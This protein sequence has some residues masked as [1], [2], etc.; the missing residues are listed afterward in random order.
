MTDRIFINYRRADSIGTAGRLRD[1]LAETFGQQNFFM[2]VDS[3]PA[4]VDFVADLNSQVAQCNVF[5]VVI[6]A[7]W[8]DS[9]DE[10]GARRLDKPDDFV[11]IEIAAALARDMRQVSVIPVLVDGARMARAD[12]LPASIQPLS[13]RQAVELRNA[14]FGRDVEIL[15][16]KVRQARGEWAAG[17]RR[18]RVVAGAAAL[19]VAILAGSIAYFWTHQRATWSVANW[20]SLV[21]ISTTD[22][23]ICTGAVIAPTAVL[24][25]ANC[26]HQQEPTH[27]QVMTVANDGNHI[28]LGDPIPVSKID[29]NPEYTHSGRWPQND[30]AILEL[31]MKLPPPFAKI[32]AQRSSDPKAGDLAWVGIIDFQSAPATFL[33]GSVAIWDDATCA[34]K[35]GL[36]GSALEK[37]I[38]AGSEHTRAGV[39]PPSGSAGGPLLISNRADRKLQ[40]GFVSAANCNDPEAAY[41]IYTRISSYAD[42]IKKVAPDAFTEP[43]PE[44]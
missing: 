30:I 27:Y 37:I 26:V 4:G 13:Q 18:V 29:I 34:V 41:G 7:N 6:G 44:R 3:I 38:C 8:L 21:S 23:I 5:L 39:C 43:A 40:I 24:S 10:S 35:S 1:R 9:T 19:A 31:G 33:K 25:A 16:A 22:G 32:S 42:W 2:D 36:Q 17:W 28:K 20:P 11:T 15:V 12:Q 14:E